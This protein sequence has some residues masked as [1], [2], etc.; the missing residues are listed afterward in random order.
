L[1]GHTEARHEPAGRRR[2][3]IDAIRH[4]SLDSP[5]S[6]SLF[7]DY[8]FRWD[9]CDITAHLIG[10]VVAGSRDDVADDGGPRR[11]F[12]DDEDRRWVV[13]EIEAPAYD[14]GA[15]KSLMYSGEGVMRRVW[16]YPADWFFL[17]DAELYDVSRRFAPARR[18]P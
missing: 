14:P 2:S 3:P 8:L 17:S 13:R 12:Y 1:E 15:G 16:T 11:E 9:S 18:R 6:D 5:L 4:D 7:R 10:G